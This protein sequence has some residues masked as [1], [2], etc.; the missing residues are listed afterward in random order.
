MFLLCPELGH[1]VVEIFAPRLS[2]SRKVLKNFPNANPFVSA[3]P[4]VSFLNM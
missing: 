4:V 2:S 3:D 1:F